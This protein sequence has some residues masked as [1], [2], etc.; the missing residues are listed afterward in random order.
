MLWAVLPLTVLLLVFVGMARAGKGRQD[1]GLV[2]LLVISAFVSLSPFLFGKN[3]LYDNERLF[4]PVFPF[5]AALTGIGFG[6]ALTGLRKLAERMKRPG[7]LVPASIVLAV[8]LLLPQSVTMAGLYPHLL[9]YYSEGVGGLPGATKLGFE[10]TY[11]CETYAA[12]LPYI[13]AHAKPGDRIWVEPWSHDVLIYY[14]M[15]G[16]LRPDVKIL[17]DVPGIGSVFGPDAPQPVK[18]TYNG[19]E[20]YIFQYRQTQY[21]EAGNDY[22]ILTYVKQ[23]APPVYEVSYQGVPLMQLYHR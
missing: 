11:W 4:M 15:H 6:W 23:L 1:N 21:G 16:Q 13:N 12:A 19:A 5:L 9:S 10:T 2:W 20:W 8:V 22:P 14:Q 7:L 18:G 17:I 3:L